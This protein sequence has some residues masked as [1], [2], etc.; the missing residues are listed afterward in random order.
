MG[1]VEIGPKPD[2]R[3]RDVAWRLHDGGYCGVLR[4]GVVSQQVDEG[5]VD[6][7]LGCRTAN[8]YINVSRFTVGMT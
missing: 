1:G 2:R 4:E 7:F 8:I 6:F 5:V 3:L